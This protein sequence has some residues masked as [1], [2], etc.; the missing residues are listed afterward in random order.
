MYRKAFP[1]CE[2]EGP[3]DPVE[4]GHMGSTKSIPRKC[5]ECDKQF[6]GECIRAVEQVQG[7]LSLD[8][9]PCKQYGNCEPKLVEDQFIKSKVYVPAKC[10]RCSHLE[11]HSIFGF[12]CHEDEEIWGPYGKTLD[13]GHWSPELPNIGLESGKLVSTELLDAVKRNEKV[14]AIKIFRTLNPGTNIKEGGEAYSE[15]SSKL[16]DYS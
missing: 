8:Y 14:E 16:E 6:E 11:Y 12:A 15:L 10:V 3:L 7:Y 2:V 1:K 9:G 4:W 5:F 13:W